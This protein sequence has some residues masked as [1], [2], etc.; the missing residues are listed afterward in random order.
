MALIDLK[1]KLS[2]GAGKI[3]QGVRNTANSLLSNQ[4]G[5]GKFGISIRKSVPEVPKYTDFTANGGKK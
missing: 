2:I 3:Q 5:I 1:S 4:R